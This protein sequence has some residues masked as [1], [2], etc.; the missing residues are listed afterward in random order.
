MFVLPRFNQTIRI[1]MSAG[2]TPEMR[3]A[4]PSVAGRI[5]ISFCRASIRKLGTSR[6]IESRRDL[7]VLQVLHPGNLVLLAGDVACILNSILD[8][9]NY[10]I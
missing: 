1:P 5:F 2:D 10:I 6:I 9:C 8:L 3:D 4:W 7:L